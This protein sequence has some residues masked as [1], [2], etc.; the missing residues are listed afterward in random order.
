MLSYYVHYKN[1]YPGGVVQQGES[2]LDV[3][4]VAGEHAVAL[5]KNGAG[6]W[7]D[8][9]EKYGCVDKHDLSPIPKDARVYKVIDSKVAHD[10]LAQERIEK[11]KELVRDGKILSIDE[12]K[13]EA[14]ALAKAEKEAQSLK[15]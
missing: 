1:K 5:R 2:F 8:E 12:Y 4:N 11:R 14:T 3:Y 13:V 9:S 6:Q 7:V 10:D 15:V